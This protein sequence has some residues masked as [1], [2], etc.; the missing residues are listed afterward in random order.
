MNIPLSKLV[1]AL[2]IFLKYESLDRFSEAGS[3][4]L[5]IDCDPD[6]VSVEDMESLNK[7]GFYASD[8]GA[9]FELR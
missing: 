6:L 7:L 5:S 2:E 4:G 3:D 8:Y 9:F 1:I